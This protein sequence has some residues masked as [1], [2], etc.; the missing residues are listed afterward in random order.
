MQFNIEANPRPT[1]PL[2]C[3]RLSTLHHDC[4]VYERLLASLPPT[5]WKS[6]IFNLS[7]MTIRKCCTVYTISPLITPE[8]VFHLWGIFSKI[9]YSHRIARYNVSDHWIYRIGYYV[10]Y[11]NLQLSPPNF[12]MI[13]YEDLLSS[14]NFD[15]CLWKFD[16]GKMRAK[17]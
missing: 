14:I 16:A 13:R 6:L 8:C 3:P 11:P 9:W 10:H 5:A 2:G 17:P 4:S 1:P 15:S 7:N 12:F